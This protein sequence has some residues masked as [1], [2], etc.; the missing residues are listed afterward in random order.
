MLFVF[1]HCETQDEKLALSGRASFHYSTKVS[2][3]SHLGCLFVLYTNVNKDLV[4]ATKLAGGQ[5]EDLGEIK[6]RV[7]LLAQSTRGR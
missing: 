7:P 6:Y 1:N 3:H 5:Q 4:V 2:R